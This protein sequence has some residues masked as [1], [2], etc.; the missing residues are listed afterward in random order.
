M[1]RNKVIYEEIVERMNTQGYE[2]DWEAV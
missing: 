2:F 1:T